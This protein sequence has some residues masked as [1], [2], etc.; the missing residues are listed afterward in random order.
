MFVSEVDGKRSCKKFKLCVL[1]NTSIK[2]CVLCKSL[3]NDVDWGHEPQRLHR[4]VLYT[5]RGHA[6]EH[7]AGSV[8]PREPTGLL[9]PPPSHT[10]LQR[11]NRTGFEDSINNCSVVFVLPRTLSSLVE[12][13]EQYTGPSLLAGWTQSDWNTPHASHSHGGTCL[14]ALTRGKLGHCW[15]VFSK[16][17][18]RAAMFH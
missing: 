10:T 17:F 9:L 6:G 4:Q 3:A 18:V 8:S 16:M 14:H 1:A 7:P 13:C 15:G 11:A 12:A 2:M 5:A